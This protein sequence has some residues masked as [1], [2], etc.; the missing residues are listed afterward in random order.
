MIYVKFATKGYGNEYVLCKCSATDVL[1]QPAGPVMTHM[2]SC[3]P[4]GAGAALR[5]GKQRVVCAVPLAAAPAAV[6]Y[7][8]LSRQGCGGCAIAQSWFLFVIRR[9][10]QCRVADEYAGRPPAC[11]DRRVATIH[12][13]NIHAYCGMPWQASRGTNF[14]NQAQ[15]KQ[16]ATAIDKRAIKI[17]WSSYGYLNSFH[18]KQRSAKKKK[19]SCSFALVRYDSPPPLYKYRTSYYPA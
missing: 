14:D 13:R 2:C 8:W 10:V 6:D 5:E 17:F 19:V 7:P 12:N 11:R 1:P 9:A 3:C 15:H 4:L 18:G 16:P